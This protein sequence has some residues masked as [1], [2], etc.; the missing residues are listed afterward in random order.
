MNDQPTQPGATSSESPINSNPTPPATPSATPQ[1]ELVTSVTKEAPTSPNEALSANGIASRIEESKKPKKGLII[2]IIAIIAVLLIG[3]GVFATVYAIYNQPANIIASSLNNLINADQVEIDGSINLAF[4][5][6]GIT[7]IESISLNFDD[8]VTGLSNTTAA[9]FNV[10]FNNGINAPA[11]EFGEVMLSDGVLYIEASGLK[12]FYDEVFRDNIKNTLMEQALYSY[13]TTTVDC[14]NIDNTAKYTECLEA[15]YS[16]VDIDPATKSAVSDNIDQI[17]DQIDKIISSID[18][19]WIEIS[20]DD[21]LNSEMLA[22][23]DLSTRQTISDSYKCTINTINQHSSYSDEISDLYTKNSFVDMTAAN[24]SFYN[25]SFN[26]D[27]LASFLN[28]IPS[29]KF[30]NDL[31][32]CYDTT[33]PN[34]T[35]NITHDNANDM[36]E[37]LPHISAKFDGFLDH[38]LTDL[39][40]SE[41]NEYYSIDADLKFSYPNNIVIS[42]PS[43]S[44]PVM[45]VVTEFYQDMEDLQSL[46]AF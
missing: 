39:K 46:Y 19:Q 10:N 13:Q 2:A 45:D 34:D 25:I 22:N 16:L 33:I 28:A 31:A 36:L 15:S 5:D 14:Y 30:A 27:N 7:S 32:K 18:G 42:A 1:A 12:D 23:I 4:Q 9:T 21:V 6:S 35:V 8:R 20:I 3:G 41:Q 24:D 26:A 37:Y 38:R 44:R 17:L 11:V 29:T 43:N 40:I